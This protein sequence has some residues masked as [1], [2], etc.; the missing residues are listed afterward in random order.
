MHKADQS[1]GFSRRGVLAGGS[2]SAFALMAGTGFAVRQNPAEALAAGVVFEDRGA[3][4][5]RQSGDP[6]IAGAL[7]SNGRDI[8]RT[9]ADGRWRLPVADGDVVF[10]IKP[11]GW[12]TPVNACGI[13]QFA[14]S[15]K[16]GSSASLD[17]PLYRTTESSQFSAL[18]LA[19]TQPGNDAELAFLREDIICGTLGHQAAFAI[20][21]GDVVFD[22]C[23]LYP[24]YLRLLGAT[25]IPWH[26]CP[27]NHDIDLAARDDASSRETWKGYFGPRHYAFQY[28]GA[29]F[30]IMDNVYY[31]GH[32]PGFP[33]SGQYCGRIGERQLQFLRNLLG[34]IPSD[35]LIVLSMHIPLTTHQ[36]PAN[37]A[38]NTGDRHALMRLLSGR[39]HTV[40]FSGHMHLS[41]HH[42]LAAD[43]G[44]SGLRP[45]HHQVL[46]AASGGWWSG[47]RDPQGLPSADCVDGHPHGFYV[48][49]VDGPRHATRF[50]PAARKGAAQLRCSIVAQSGPQDDPH[51]VAPSEVLD[52]G[53]LA[54][55]RLVANVFDGGPNT[56][57][58]IEI[59]GRPGQI[60]MQPSADPDPATLALF[61]RH[62][63][64][65]QPWM[66]A[67]PTA[68]IWSAPFPHGLEA[69]AHRLTVRARNE[70]GAEHVAHMVVEIAAEQRPHT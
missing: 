13:P 26:H 58:A 35:E 28:A 49:D 10:L 67:V 64:T 25:G 37:A 45:H 38:D 34:Y 16:A 57:V 19:D 61:A 32:A 3:A 50:V 44:F 1:K 46:A 53:A 23:D 30:I 27:G 11:S 22:N 17:F 52:Q 12:T 6:G 8:V 40:S 54:R 20:N 68:H 63:Q 65:I 47:P 43:H 41:E 62:R 15:P 60:A 33:H 51:L 36:D 2:A 42:Y 48:L 70:F 56:R 69:G 55:Y 66:R 24:R 59:A 29:T 4:G 31:S 9:G 5:V 21:H 14:R 39:P 7:V 18:L